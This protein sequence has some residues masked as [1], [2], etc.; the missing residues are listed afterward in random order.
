MR[1]QRK[2]GSRNGKQIPLPQ[3]LAEVEDDRA[4]CDAEIDATNS[5]D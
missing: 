3:G 4:R 2:S 5:I 1:G